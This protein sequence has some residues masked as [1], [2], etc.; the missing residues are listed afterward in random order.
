[1]KTG[2][3]S[4]PVGEVCSI[5]GGGTPSRSNPAYYG[6]KIPWA[7]IRD[8]KA[9]WIENTEFSITAAAVKS[10]ATNVLPA[11]TVIVASRVGL[12]K[13]CRIRRDTAINQDLRGFMPKSAKQ[14]DPQYLF[15]WFKSVADQIVAAGTGAT[16]QGVTLPF[17]RSLQIPLPPL[18]EQR[19]VVAV[20]D[21]ALAAIATATVNAEK[22]LANAGE[23]FDAYLDLQMNQHWRRDRIV[24]LADACDVRD[25]THDSPKYVEVGIPFV[26]QKNIRAEG[27]SFDK[28]RSISSEDHEKFYKRSN[29]EMGDII[30]SM[31]GANRGM[32]CLVDDDRIFSIKNVGLIK[33][34]D[35]F[36][37]KFLLYFLQ[38]REAKSY[39]KDQSNGGAQ[40]F[41]GLTKLREFPVPMPTVD[42]QIE[43]IGALDHLKLQS[44]RLA[45]LYTAQI[46]KIDRLKQ[47]FLHRAFTGELTATMPETIA[48]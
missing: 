25:G 34:S 30:I 43:S 44:D 48:A 9:D 29:V 16:V 19:R 37:M 22:N 38:S 14:L 5:V 40:E 24:R 7:T 17:L 13:V 2:W 23:L 18:P 21:E 46:E 47:S 32:S 4:K 10:S 33:S 28:C 35:D 27:L 3:E 41:I 8:M 1:M 39:V 20:L 42:R 6:G 36:D 26:T 15:L 11:G 31:I 45:A 12:G